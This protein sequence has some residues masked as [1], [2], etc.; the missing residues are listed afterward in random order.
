MSEP[1]L[2]LGGSGQ[3]GTALRVLLG[4]RALVAPLEAVNLMSG[5][6][7]SQLDAF[8]GARKISALINAAAYTLV[9][10]AEDEGAKENW[11][12]N[13]IAPGLLARWCKARG[14]AFVHY[15]TDYVFDGS[16]EEPRDE[17][18]PARPLNAYGKRKLAGEEA[19]QAEGGD[20]LIFRT[21]WV[22]DAHNK[23]F[24]NTML[25]LFGDRE[26]LSVV[27]D[28]VGAPTYAPHLAQGTLAAL[29]KLAQG[30][31][32]G[33]YHLCNGGQVSWHGF[34]QAILSLARVHDS[35]VRCQSIRPI[36]STEYP[37]PAARP[38]NSRLDCGKAARLLGV[39]LPHWEAGLK[40]CIEEKYA[41][42]GL[43][44]RRPETHPA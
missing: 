17:E 34:A 12:L 27:A 11:Q 32:A 26:E 24:F 31:P 19:V 44:D 25:R 16:G 22:Y 4:A 35:G 21:S 20:Y 5:D 18:V 8:V 1:I 29:E 42:T 40:E 15:S 10:K 23:N 3:L 14:G 39:I 28:Q 37:L 7:G 41:D 38:L 2:I 36:A 33:L 30:A 9:D 43:P 13:A 6:V